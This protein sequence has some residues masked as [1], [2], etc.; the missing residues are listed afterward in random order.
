MA[1]PGSPKRTLVEGL[2]PLTPRIEISGLIPGQNK[3][4]KLFPIHF[5]ASAFRLLGVYMPLSDL[6]GI[7]SYRQELV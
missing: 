1:F 3:K 5:Q 2:E 7:K 4:Q 6:N